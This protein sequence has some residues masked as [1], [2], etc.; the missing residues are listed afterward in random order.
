MK[1]LEIEKKTILERIDIIQE[2]LKKLNQ[3]K[4]LTPGKFMLGENFAIAE[5]YLQTRISTYGFC[6]RQFL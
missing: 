6:Q 2:S 4:N 1:E 3:L 5:H